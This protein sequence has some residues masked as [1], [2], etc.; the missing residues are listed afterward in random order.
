MS[1]GALAGLL[2]VLGVVTRNTILLVHDVQGRAA[3]G[4]TGG[5]DLV[6]DG[7]RDRLAPVLLTAGTLA[8]AMLPFIV[9][10]GIAGE[11]ILY[12]MAVV[13]LGGLVTAT[14]LT[15]FVV[16]ALFLRFLVSAPAEGPAP[17]PQSS[18]VGPFRGGAS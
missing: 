4:G 2:L 11:E 7:T 15:L 12:P 1:A 8:V 6:L 16:P 9:F 17:P 3:E 18:P 14:L 13:V 10:G 5:L